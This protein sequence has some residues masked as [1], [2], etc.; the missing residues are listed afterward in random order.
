VVGAK[1]TEID[2]ERKTWVIP[3]ERLKD[4]RTR[5]EPHRMPSP[6]VA[7]ILKALPKLGEFVFPG[8]KPGKPLSNIA[9]LSVL[10]DMNC[11]ASG[12]EEEPAVDP[13]GARNRRLSRTRPRHPRHGAA[14]SGPSS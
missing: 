4:R 6:Q 14:R 8:L 10:K 9:M 3:P 7:A 13:E 1:W 11:D 5:T 2:L 12:E